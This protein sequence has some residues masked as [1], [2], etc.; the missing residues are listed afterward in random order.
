[1][2]V[3]DVVSAKYNVE[4]VH[5]AILNL[6]LTQLREAVG[7]LTL[8]E[9]FSSR[10]RINYGLLKDLNEVCV[11]W[12]VEITRVEIQNLQPSLTIQ[13]AMELQMAA[14]RKKRA[15]ILKSEGERTTYINEAEGRAQAAITNAEAQNQVTVLKAQAEAHRQRIEAEGLKVAIEAI[16][17]AIMMSSSSNNSKSHNESHNDVVQKEKA[18]EGAIQFLTVLRFLETQA[19]FASSDNSKIIMLPTKDSLPLTYGGLKFL[20]DD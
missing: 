1:M 20:M 4:D 18:V 3:Q 17:T 2:R 7:K 5:S 11:G 14:E 15:S 12:G 16:T 19:K 10:E 6:C 13:E 9:S 8:D